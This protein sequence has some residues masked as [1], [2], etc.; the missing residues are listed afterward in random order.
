M[1][2]DAVAGVLGVQSQGALACPKHFAA[3]NQDTNRFELDPEWKT[4][5]VYVDKRVLHELY[6]PAFKAA[7]QEADV[8]S[9]MCTYNMLN[10]YF[11]CENDWLRNTTLRQEWGFTGFVVADW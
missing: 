4:V 10:G 1:P 5:D 9:A 6:L 3:Y 8:A 11:T 2:A 7:V